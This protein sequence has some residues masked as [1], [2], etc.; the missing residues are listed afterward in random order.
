MKFT[1]STKTVDA[2]NAAA[3]H[4]ALALGAS[5]DLVER[6]TGTTEITTLANLRIERVGEQWEYEMNDEALFLVLRMYIRVAK[7]I[8]PLIAPA[9]ALVQGL[10]DDSEAFDDFINTSKK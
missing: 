1:I 8:V 9:I 3:T 5:A 2:L 7:F 6:L 4:E 10:K